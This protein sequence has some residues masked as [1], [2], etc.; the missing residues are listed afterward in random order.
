MIK[1]A[2]LA[3]SLLLF[4]TMSGFESS[5]SIL[6]TKEK[7]QPDDP[8]IT[9]IGKGLKDALLQGTSKSTDQLSAVDGF[10]GNA[11]IKI[12]FPPEAQKAEKTLREIGLGELCDKVIL[13]LNRAAEDAAKQAKPIFINAI[14]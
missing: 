5:H 6:K 10:F 9:E 7:T 8:S 14:K 3:S 13:S 11:A 1:K 4:L 2:L 12:L